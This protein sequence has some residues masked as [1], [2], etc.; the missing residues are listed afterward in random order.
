MDKNFIEALV[1]DY[2][3]ENTSPEK[4]QELEK[5]LLAAGY[6]HENLRDLKAF[7]YSLDE[8]PVPEPRDE[9]TAGFY[10]MLERESVSEAGKSRW[11]RFLQWWQR[12]EK[13]F[14]PK[15]GYAFLFIAIGWMLGAW[16]TPGAQYGKSISQMA[17]EI[18]SMKEMV[19]LTRL[20]QPS[21]SERMRAV[22]LVD[23][24]TEVDIE[25]ARALLQTL[26]HDS[27]VNVRLVTVET[28]ARF[29]NNPVVRQGLIRSISLQESPLVQLALADL[30]GAL[31]EK[32]SVPQ[33]YQLLAKK[34][35]NYAVR[36]RINQVVQ[37]L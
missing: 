20:K 1:I 16:V 6:S 7:Y 32:E 27:N 35:L 3:D 17:E 13:T 11:P 5:Q 31:K 30:M 33:F 37:M 22:N 10:E 12:A 28:L 2:W 25:V 21:P 18:T 15:L 24:W 8:I 14:F 29:I 34:D 26:N 9:M 4:K 36:D 23:E 19:M